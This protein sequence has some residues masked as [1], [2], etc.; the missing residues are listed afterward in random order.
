ME[1]NGMERN[2]INR[3]RMEWNGMERNGTEWNEMEWNG[4]EWNGMEWN[5]MAWNQLEF[6]EMLERLSNTFAAQR[7]FSANAAHELRKRSSISLKAF[8]SCSISIEL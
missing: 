2:G 4:M 7:Q 3:N 1:W 6:N 8:V 5:A